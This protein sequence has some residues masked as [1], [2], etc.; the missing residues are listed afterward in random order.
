MTEF[1]HNWFTVLAVIIFAT[2]GCAS[3]KSAVSAPPQ[4]RPDLAKPAPALERKV[5]TEASHN[6]EIENRAEAF[7]RYA[8]GISLQLQG[9]SSEAMQNYFEAAMADYTNQA[10]VV[11][12]CQNLLELKEDDKAFKL[13][14]KAATAPQVE[15]KIYAELSRLSLQLGKLDEAVA[16]AQKTIAFFPT[17]LAGYQMLHAAQVQRKQFSD[18]W[19]TLE[20][21]NRVPGNIPF[22]IDLAEFYAK[23]RQTSAD[24]AEP[25]RKRVIEL[26]NRARAL[27]PATPPLLMKLADGYNFIGESKTA[28]DIYLEMQAQ[29]ASSPEI[30]ANIRAKLTDIYLRGQD[31]EKATE[32]L[33]KIARDNPTNPQVYFFLG[34]LAF[35]ARKFDKAIEHFGKVILL[36]PDF[37]Q[38][39]FDMA[40]AQINANLPAEAIKTL[41]AARAR[42]PQSFT[43]EYY[44]A[45]AYNRAKL[46]AN[47]IRAFTA[48]EI[49]ASATEKI[50][51][52][53]GF[54]FQLGACYERNKQ[55]EEAE[56]Y[57]QKAIDMDANSAEALNY[58]GYMWAERGVN[59]ERAKAYIEKALKLMPDN[60]AYLDS[61]GWLY[62]RQGNHKKALDLIEKAIVKTE[63][64]DP[65]LYE[66][67]GDIHAALRQWP[68]ARE[69]WKK[70]LEIEANEAVKKKLDAAPQ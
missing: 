17:N 19:K 60:G 13:L 70:S 49:V 23:F 48:A 53:A 51:L 61:L 40:G 3:R 9:Q 36:N 46:Y 42:F 28:A 66:H 65:T 38:A 45:L 50:R 6:K 68:K 56:K 33:E 7:A 1:N 39:Y 63:E 20:T 32:M 37:T 59:L 8:A 30:L 15:G 29:F 26:L 10:L 43:L 67:L 58:L 5:V 55:N 21:A 14:S 47:A 41:Q 2:S 35:E 25:A 34:G 31:H 62:Y 69:A 12:V 11:E 54:Y 22:L 64:P 52:N 24:Y 27:K 57:M 18:A 4:K 44:T 16:A